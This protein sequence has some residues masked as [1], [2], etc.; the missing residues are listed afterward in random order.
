VWP[1]EVVRDGGIV[2]EGRGSAMATYQ[3]ET[4]EKAREARVKDVEK[5]K[6]FSMAV[7]NFWLD[8]ALLVLLTVYL[9]L[10]AL[11]RFVFPAPLSAAGWTLWGWTFDEWWDF[12]FDVLCAFFF[13]VGVHVMLHWNWVCSL[14]ASKIVRTR[15]PDDSLQTIYGVLLLIVVLHAIAI[16]L[17]AGMY[18][19]HKPH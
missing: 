1:D 13:G 2:V 19:I 12:Q 18:Y 15:R 14:V 8:A 5:G 10:A 6:Y 11:L 3:G 9:W 4:N 16:G 7:V 17:I